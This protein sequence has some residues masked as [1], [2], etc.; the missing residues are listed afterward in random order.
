LHEILPKLDVRFTLDCYTT[1]ELEMNFT[2][3]H[4]ESK[5]CYAILYS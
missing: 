5:I 4:A 2:V 3:I 1:I